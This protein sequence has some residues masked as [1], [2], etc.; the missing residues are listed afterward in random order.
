[1]LTWHYE[2]NHI[3]MKVIHM[4]IYKYS[5]QLVCIAFL[6]MGSHVCAMEWLAEQ[7]GGLLQ[8]VNANNISDKLTDLGNSKL[9]QAM[10]DL[11]RGVGDTVR[12]IEREARAAKERA[13][14]A[15]AEAK[16]AKLRELQRLQDQAGERGISEAVRLRL[17]DQIDR[18]Q[19]QMQAQEDQN[20][21]SQERWDVLENQ[22]ASF[23]PGIAG[24]AKDM[25]LEQQKG[26]I[27]ARKANI[28]AYHAR[29]GMGEAAKEQ[30]EA[31]G[32]WLKQHPHYI[33]LIAG[34][35][36]ATWQLAKFGGKA[37]NDWYDIPELCDRENT[38]LISTPRK[39]Y[40]WL[41]GTVPPPA[42]LSNAIF[43][44]DLQARIS[45]ITDS[46]KVIVANGGYLP[47]M[48]FW[49]PP[50]TGKTLVAKLMARSCG[51]EFAYFSGAS[52]DTYSVEVGLQL[53]TSLFRFAGTY[54]K[55]LMI[56][57]D[58]AEAVLADRGRPGIS[59]KTR[60]FLTHILT[61]TGTET[62][63]YCVVALTNRPEDLDE[64]YRSRCDHMIHIGAPAYTQI[65]D[66]LRLYINN[67]LID[68]SD[69]QPDKPS[70]FTRFFR[71]PAE[72]QKPKIEEGALSDEVIEDLARQ[73]S[74][75]NFVGRDI[76]KLVGSIRS[77]AFA[78]KDFV[79]TPDIVRRVVATKIGEKKEKQKM[80][81][82]A[83]Q[84]AAA[85]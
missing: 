7:A 36:F 63:N 17:L 6:L 85:A 59:D 56:I 48:L 35:V 84:M 11:A 4:K 72:A 3:R 27:A 75:N 5:K 24:M 73:L 23:F 40:N 51:M 61:Y 22:A 83:P 70:I 82:N 20:A 62:R 57:I 81:A 49:G 46:L 41:T 65:V 10:G 67:L 9:A 71:K 13:A 18:I 64:A 26:A 16:A 15:H 50:G 8:G 39:F 55:R 37:L 74:K 45:E 21:R 47:N 28:E 60:K 58:E 29:K 2:F 19:K 80:A 42:K 76:F 66:I 79:V 38:S 68:A 31:W 30:A 1:M 43:D 44:Q 14:R 78:N 54:P 12:D 53:L 32:K 69:M 33:P 52:L 34:G 25:I 77:T